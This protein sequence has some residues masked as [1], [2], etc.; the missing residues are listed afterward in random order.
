MVVVPSLSALFVFTCI[1]VDPPYQK[2]GLSA[3]SDTSLVLDVNGLFMIEGHIFMSI[4]YS[5]FSTD[6]S[7]LC[8]SS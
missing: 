5:P 8:S 7:I 2:S 1:R 4:I 6:V 3:R